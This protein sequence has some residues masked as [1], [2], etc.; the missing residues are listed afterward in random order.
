[1]VTFDLRSEE[2]E[3]GRRKSGSSGQQVLPLALISLRSC[4]D[5]GLGGGWA[6]KPKRSPGWEGHVP[7]LSQEGSFWHPEEGLYD[8]DL[9]LEEEK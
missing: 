8:R 1:M 4:T 9:P 5:M 2:W 6:E 3:G 7:R